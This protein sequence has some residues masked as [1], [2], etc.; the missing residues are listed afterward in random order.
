MPT[1]IT[2]NDLAIF[3]ELA[4]ANYHSTHTLTALFGNGKGTYVTSRLSR[5]VKDHFL[6]MTFFSDMRWGKVGSPAIYYLAEKALALVHLDPEHRHLLSQRL[7][8]SKALQGRTLRHNILRSKFRTC[9]LLMSRAST[10]RIDR[11]MQ[12]D[13]RFP[14]LGYASWIEDKE[15]RE[16]EINPDAFFSIEAPSCKAF[17]FF[18]EIDMVTYAVSRSDM[19]QG[20]SIEKKLILYES[21]LRERWRLEDLEASYFRLIFVVK[22]S[23]STNPQFKEQRVE[24]IRAI[25]E[26]DEFANIRKC[27]RFVSECDLGFGEEIRFEDADG[28][29]VSLFD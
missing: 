10:W 2:D 16:R 21:L 8:K 9:L 7:A 15:Q 19:T 29:T 6:G 11:W 4:I 24:S 17:H 1:S 18:L 3:E 28:T 12:H 14:I 5:L 26:R 13:R 20:S 23:N 27:V 22:A 25:L